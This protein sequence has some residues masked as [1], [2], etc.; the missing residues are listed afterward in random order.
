MSS[1][2]DSSK[3]AAQIETTAN[4]R[5][6]RERKLIREVRAA[7]GI[8]A[9]AC[10][11]TILG[12]IEAQREIL[13]S[14]SDLQKQLS[15]LD[16]SSRQARALA[17][18]SQSAALEIETRLR[19]LEGQITDLQTQQTALSA[20]YRD[21]SI[22]KEEVVL[23]EVERAVA[24]ANQELLLAGD[25]RLAIRAM[26][27]AERR[28]ERIDRPSLQG[29]RRVVDQDL[30]RLRAIPVADVSGM[31]LR[32]ENLANAVDQ[33]PLAASARPLASAKTKEKKPEG[34]W[35]GLSEK[36]L[37][38]LGEAVRI[39]RSQGE[40]LPPLAPDQ[41]FFLRQNLRL[42]L[43]TA[44]QALLSHDDTNYRG[45]LKLASRWLDNWYDKQDRGVKQASESL[46]LMIESPTSIN[47]P[48]VAASLS[49]IRDHQSTRVTG[50]SK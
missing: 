21:L 15:D 39:Q 43:L 35:T 20:L 7:M 1:I 6:P 18:Q 3:Q 30:R 46:R 13:E 47:L 32:L 5:T 42:R 8:A 26:E 24:I 10:V 28:L 40:A 31:S 2:D 22:N 49:A 50:H 14:R 36:L 17:A 48:D 41:T 37:T 45:D 27:D 11:L 38:E 25:V 33:L 12:S 4:T 44:R 19:G 29:I 16:A 9:L 23:A 34:F